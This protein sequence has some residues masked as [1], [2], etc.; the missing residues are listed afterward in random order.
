MSNIDSNQ[1]NKSLL[2]QIANLN[3]T[4]ND[5]SR[6]I[7]EMVDSLPAIRWIGYGLLILALFDVI[8][9][10]IPAKFLNPN[11][12]FQTFGALV[13]RV[14]VP[15]IGFAFVFIAGLNERGNKEGIILKFLSWL[16]LLLGIIYFI[17]VP[18]GVINTA[19]IYKQQQGQITARLNQQKAAIEQVKKNLD[20]PINEVQMQ[21]ILAQLSGGRAP[22]LKNSEELQKAKQQLSDFVNKGESELETQVQTARTNQRINLLKKSVKWNLGALISGALFITIWRNTGWARRA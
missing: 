18:L 13:E 7:F 10:F 1:S 12:E 17:T 9:M 6:F 21:Q 14:A 16:T 11:W 22:E 20:G 4:T 15:L 2:A 5:F 19:R 8:E 3:Q